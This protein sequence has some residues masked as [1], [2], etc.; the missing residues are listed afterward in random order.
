MQKERERD[1]VV[2]IEIGFENVEVLRF[3]IGA[4]E[5]VDI[6]D[7]RKHYYGCRG[8]SAPF[9]PFYKAHGHVRLCIRKAANDT[10]KYRP[11]MCEE[12]TPFQRLKC[13]PD[14]TSLDLIYSDGTRQSIWVPFDGEEESVL[15]STYED[16][17]GNLCLHIRPRLKKRGRT[18]R[19]WGRK[20]IAHVD[21]S[22]VYYAMGLIEMDVHALP[23]KDVPDAWYAECEFIH[24]DLRRINRRIGKVQFFSSDSW[25]EAEARYQWLRKMVSAPMEAWEKK[26]APVLAKWKG[27]KRNRPV[28][29]IYEMECVSRGLAQILHLIEDEFVLKGLRRGT[30]SSDAPTR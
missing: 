3:D 4:F 22:Y 15:Q 12:M 28:R 18:V 11:S 7:V 17:D 20:G 27:K 13:S 10:T 5:Q 6:G 19:I 16:E 8:G 14:V 24:D 1:N 21:E 9:E 25:E 2:A 23:T 29:A 30:G 26:S